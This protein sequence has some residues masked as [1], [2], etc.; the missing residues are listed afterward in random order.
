MHEVDLSMCIVY[1][2]YLLYKYVVVSMSGVKIEYSAY[3]H[4]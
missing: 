3:K 2:V 1:N 4:K